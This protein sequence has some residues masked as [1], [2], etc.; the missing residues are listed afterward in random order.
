MQEVN[1][2]SVTLIRLL[3]PFNLKEF[4]KEVVNWEAEKTLDQYI[5]TIDGEHGPVEFVASVNGKLVSIKDWHETYLLKDDNIIICPI[6]G[7]SG[8]KSIFKLVALI[9]ISVFAPQLA[10]G[11]LG[12]ALAGTTI[13]GTALTY[14]AVLGTVISFVGGQLVNS[15][16]PNTASKSDKNKGGDNLGSSPTY[17][18]DGAKNVSAEGVPVPVVYGS[19]R[20]GGNLINAFV[21][22][23]GNSQYIYLLF[24]ASE[25]P[26]SGINNILVNDQPIENFKEV[27]TDFRTGLAS[28]PLMPW[29]G[30]T[31]IP[32]TVGLKITQSFQTFNTV[33]IVDK[34]RFDIAFPGGLYS[35]N[36]ENGNTEGRAVELNIQYRK[37]GD[38]DWMALGDGSVIDHY[39]RRY[40]IK[41]I[42]Y[43]TLPAGYID[44]ATLAVGQSNFFGIGGV[45]TSYLGINST[46]SGF[47]IVSGANGYGQ[48]SINKNTVYVRKGVGVGFSGISVSYTAAGTAYSKPFY[49]TTIKV[50]A[51]QR[52]TL[53]RS[54]ITDILPQGKY[55][56][57]YS[58]VLAESTAT[59]VVDIV[60]MNEI[61]EIIVDDVQYNNTAL[62]G[63]RILLSD[64]LNG[65]PKVT[66][67]IEGVQIRVWDGVNKVFVSQTSNNPAW[68]A[69]DMLTNQRYGAGI[70][71]SR[72]DLEKWKVWAN[73]CDTFNLTFNGVFD[74]TLTM[75]DALQYVFRCGHAQVNCIGTRYTVAIERAESAVMMFTV[76]NMIENSFVINWLPA[77]D[78]AND[79]DV[80][81]F[82]ATDGYKQKTVKVTDQYAVAN[83]LPLKNAAITLFGVID[84]RRAY[85]E[86]LIALAMNKYILQ[87]VTFEAAI[88]AIAC[89]VGDVI[90]V[91][92][93]MPQWGYAGR[94]EVGS[95]VSVVN[96]DRPMSM[97][98]GKQYKVLCTFDSIQ[99][100]SGSISNILGT[101][102]YL[103]GYSGNTSVK[104]IIIGTKDLEVLSIFDAGAGTYGVI[105]SDVTGLSTGNAYALYD[106]DVLE[107]RDVVV[108]ATAEDY[109]SVTLTSPF[110]IAPPI[111]TNFMFGETAKIKKPFRVRAMNGS[112]EYSR[113]IVAIEYNA[114][115]Y[116]PDAT[117]IVPTANYSALN[118]AITS[119]TVSGVTESLFPLGNGFGV[120]ATINFTN[121]NPTY[122]EAKVFVSRAGGAFVDVGTGV[123]SKT[124]TASD[125]EALIFKLVAISVLGV[126]EPFSNAPT[127]SYTV[128]GKSAP[129]ANVK[130]FIGIASKQIITFNWT[131][132]AD[133]DVKEYEIRLGTSWSSSAFIERV[134][135]NTDLI[136]PTAGANLS[137]LIK[138]LDTTGHYSVTE[139]QAS[140]AVT[141][142]SAITL[143]A[144][145]V[146]SDLVLSWNSSV[147]TF[148]IKGYELREG[149]TYVTSTIIAVVNANSF[150]LPITYIGSKTYYLKAIDVASNE[151]AIS[152]S[153]VTVNSPSAVTIS[154]STSGDTVLIAW[155]KPSSSLPIAGYEIKTGTTYA[156]A[157]SIKKTSSLSLGYTTTTGDWSGDKTFWVTA[158]DV[159]GNYGTPVSRVINITPPDVVAPSYI[160]EG[161]Q[162]KVSW[163]QPASKLVIRG[164]TV[165]YGSSFAAGT[166]ISDITGTSLSFKGQ[167]L[168]D[169]NIYVA[170]Y[171]SAGNYGTAGLVTATI[172]AP[173]APALSW[174]NV[175]VS[176]K[177]N[178]T[179]PAASLPIIEYEIRY[180]SSF[181][182]GVSIGKFSA[183]SVNVN[184]NWIGARTFFIAATDSAGNVGAVGSTTITFSAPVA[185]TGSVSI[186]SD[187][188]IVS[189]SSSPSTTD[190]P[191]DRYEL[192]YGGTSFADATVIGSFYTTNYT[193]IVNYLGNRTYRI[194]AIDVNQNVG[195]I[196][197]LT[198]NIQIPS[199]VSISPTVVDNNILLKWSNSTGSLSIASYK[200]LKG[201]VYAS[202]TVVGTLSSNF[203][204]LFESKG[205]MYKYWVVAL[206]TAGNIGVE[207]SVTANVS[208]PPDYVLNTSVDSVFG[209]TKTNAILEFGNLL[210]PISTTETFS[211]HFTAY[212]RSS[213][214]DQIAAGHPVY[215]EPV[216]S[217]GSYTETIDY[218]TILPST[219]VTVTPTYTIIAGAPNI[220]C[221]IEV[222]PDNATWTVFNNTF[223]ALAVNLR[224][225]RI[226][227]SVATA[228][229]DDIA[230]ISA[231]NIKLSSKLSNDAG[232]GV[233]NASDVGGTQVNFKFAFVDVESLSV[234]PKGTTFVIAV[235]DFVDAPYPTG[236]KVLLFDK[237]GNRLSGDFSWA[238]K[239]Y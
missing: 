194:A 123:S 112:G 236:F 197:N 228:S 114:S 119:V 35:I 186:R 203:S 229:G 136:V 162:V 124:V 56:T 212:S 166:L 105:V 92:H 135:A 129:P 160:F 193:E 75:W 49:K 225:A 170:A 154:D 3:N 235:Y 100:A 42:T 152:S 192:R 185:P 65:L 147:G 205:G 155:L 106:T 217:T 78:R 46:S 24:A 17:G 219:I 27:E 68:C 113:Q 6:I 94:L 237:N 176:G 168:G 174:S 195:D 126:Q 169:R 32:R 109:M 144:A 103:T 73:H 121:S 25:G 9:A 95:T 110:S 165:K 167:W 159:K 179:V 89:T 204:A 51:A 77:A 7:K 158:Y 211:G 213:P 93:D 22:N 86:G 132:V 37:V 134:T 175:G 38:I 45:G 28:Q 47:G 72:I 116:N 31:V 18:Y 80:T 146:E 14:G 153:T 104:R 149:S 53:R 157:L 122:K 209:G 232:S 230:S 84:S 108:P 215:A 199:A 191:I 83:G 69:L 11:I 234:T 50:S 128:I 216:S 10:V 96:F 101:S 196:L 40:V 98:V 70:P 139:G 5:P 82:E 151:S 201:D 142:P 26:I 88:D 23:K 99:R 97:T 15:L 44:G 30:D 16:F 57:R 181:A 81:Y 224:Y 239:G 91:Q 39:E 74:T 33:D 63:M 189:W 1:N 233:A 226:T 143:S 161:Q 173:L 183:N 115:I 34:L 102:L 52:T 29:F 156:T 188:A 67:M 111:Y 62:F 164:Y 172:V 227:L 222:S 148:D 208:Q 43:A 2:Q 184:V 118:F 178:W 19:Y 218:G 206:D 117:T 61:N 138:A 145:I 85:N 54:F 198:T 59:N 171:D 21:E 107:E 60:S 200:V 137:Y 140:V 58:R 127:Y 87:T 187:S 64:Q 36:T 190:I 180:G 66:F 41:G 55:E 202:A 231:L 4:D 214:Q 177:L 130:D 90:Y 48:Q 76:A 223:T 150:K 79:I 71:D 12:P 238:A 8:G 120:S 20:A 125:G 210:M 133:I 221:K 13:L 163:V 182:S 131:K 207:A 220:V 141:L